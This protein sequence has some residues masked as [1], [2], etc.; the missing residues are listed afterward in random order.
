MKWPQDDSGTRLVM[1]R[2]QARAEAKGAPVAEDGPRV[3]V[4]AVGTSPLQVLV[5]IAYARSAV[6]KSP[7]WPA[8]GA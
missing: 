4:G 6:T 3:E 8:S 7:M 5:G 1:D 2:E